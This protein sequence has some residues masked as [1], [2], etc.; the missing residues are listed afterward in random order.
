MSKGNNSS[1]S[2]KRFRSPIFDE[3]ALDNKDVVSKHSIVGNVYPLLVDVLYKPSKSSKSSKSSNSVQQFKVVSSSLFIFPERA[4][5]NKVSYIERINSYLT[6]LDKCVSTMETTAPGWVYRIYVDYSVFKTYSQI[7][8]KEAHE[9]SEVVIRR[10]DALIDN[11]GSR[12]IIEIFGCRSDETTPTFMPSIWRFLPMLDESVTMMCPV[13]LD[14]PVSE[15]T[16]HFAEQWNNDPDACDMMFIA[17]ENYT[18]PHC[19]LYIAS[20]MDTADDGVC[21]VAQFWFWRRVPGKSESDTFKRLFELS[22]DENIRTFFKHLD[23]VWINKTVRKAIVESSEFQQLSNK[24]VTPQETLKIACKSVVNVLKSTKDESSVT[25]S[26]ASKIASMRTAWK[27]TVLEDPRL[28]EFVALMAVGHVISDA[29]GH[30]GND[31][32]KR[33]MKQMQST[34]VSLMSDVVLKHGYG[35]DEWLLHTIMRPGDGK[36]CASLLTSSTPH[37]GVVSRSSMRLHNSDGAPPIVSWI[38]DVVV[39]DCEEFDDQQGRAI[40]SEYIVRTCAML[41]ILSPDG[42]SAETVQARWNGMRDDY[43]ERL[44]RSISTQENRATFRREVRKQLLNNEGF[45]MKGCIRRFLVLTTSLFTPWLETL[46]ATYNAID[47]RIRFDTLEGFEVVKEVM[48][49]A[50]FME[51]LMLHWNKCTPV[52]EGRILPW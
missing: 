27:R 19:T 8:D 39:M 42:G 2:K 36:G 35:V 21:P 50:F 51:M 26:R 11:Y 34:E 44:E 33:M 1:I 28:V 37:I 12:G 22:K 40:A 29:Y 49:R 32:M 25:K 6:G 24:R 47:T 43:L 48:L 30:A 20:H 7:D 13:D 17:L 5:K 31:K 46:G 14:N 4:K 9:A 45:L 41:R 10:M 18:I 3:N 23:I 15:L 38:H 52:R 16:M